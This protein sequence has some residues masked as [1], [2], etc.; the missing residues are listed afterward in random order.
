[1]R[2]SR[3]YVWGFYRVIEGFFF[4]VVKCV[5]VGVFEKNVPLLWCFGGQVAVKSVANVVSGHALFEE[6]EIDKFGN[7]IFP[8]AML[9]G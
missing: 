9:S 7:F 1:M 2:S 6:L 5:F 8:Q 4:G 3:D